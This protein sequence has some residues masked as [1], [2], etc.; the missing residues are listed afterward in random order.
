MLASGRVGVVFYISGHGFGHASRQVEIIRALAR[1]RPALRVRIRSAVD[2]GLLAR[3]LDVPYE[4]LPGEVDTG[5]VQPSSISHDD[6]A[7]VTAAIAFY[8]GFERRID[9][10][11]RALAEDPPALIAGDIP[12]LAFEVASRLGIPGI[13]I[14]NFTWDWIYE[15]HPGM[16]EAAPWLVPRLKRAY[17]KATQAL[18]LPMAGGFDVFSAVERLP[19]VAR[20]PSRGREA[21]RAAFGIPADRRAALLSFGGYGLPDLDVGQL[22]LFDE[23]TIVTTDRS[24]RAS[25]AALPQVRFIPESSFIDTGFRYEDVVSAVDAVV[26]KPGYGIIAECVSTSTPMLY[27][28]RGDFREYDLLV[29]EMP[30]YL[31][32]RFIDQRDLFAGRWRAALNGLLAQ[33]APPETLAV[34]GA[35]HAARILTSWLDASR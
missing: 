16:A 24:A 28:S 17:Q 23:W 22:D 8:A 11:V 31:R 35:A 12:P 34:D 25:G 7:T 6:E 32:A 5:I 27:T 9:N 3:T 15:T 4:L 2:P 29:R 30:K 1:G 26:T 14:A 20:V 13:A 10:E 21:T 33:P 18:E 19:L